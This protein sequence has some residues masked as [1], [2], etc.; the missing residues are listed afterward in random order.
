MQ[1]NEHKKLASKCLHLDVV[2]GCLVKKVDGHP[3]KSDC[4]TCMAYLGPGRGLG[5][6]VH[7][8]IQKLGL[9]KLVSAKKK[10]A[11]VFINKNQKVT[12]TKT[13]G[14]NCG[15]RRAALNNLIPSR[16]N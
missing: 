12:R 15:K 16:K 3:T 4:A 8:V 5:D 1:K 10:K 7:A 2:Q 6:K 14:C 11:V 13:G 9:D